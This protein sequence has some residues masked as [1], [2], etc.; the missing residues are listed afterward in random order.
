MKLSPRNTRAGLSRVSAG[1]ALAAAV[2]ACLSMGARTLIAGDDPPMSAGGGDAIGS[3]PFHHGAPP[4]LPIHGMSPSISFEGPSLQVIQEQIVDA[5]GA[6]YCELFNLPSG[7]VRVEIQGPVTLVLDRNLLGSHGVTTG[8]DVTQGFSAGM[9][10]ITQAPRP[11]RTQLLP[12]QGDF[13]LPLAN[14]SATG[15]LDSGP[16]NVHSV[17]LTGLHHNFDMSCSGGTLRLV[18][19]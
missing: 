16:M 8:L 5:Y 3:L 12:G 19:H 18:T 2:F 15:A 17:S 4:E 10:I 14:L 11:V 7:A 13:C 9:A 1:L 6:G